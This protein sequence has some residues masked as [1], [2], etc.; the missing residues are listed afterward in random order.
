MLTLFDTVLRFFPY[1]VVEVVEEEHGGFIQCVL[2][3]RESVACKR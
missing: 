3:K 1:E 2:R